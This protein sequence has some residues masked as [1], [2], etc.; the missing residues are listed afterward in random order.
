MEMARVLWLHWL[1]NH[2][3]GACNCTEDCS[4]TM[5]GFIFY[6]MQPNFQDN[7]AINKNCVTHIVLIELVL[8]LI[9]H[10]IAAVY[11]Q[12]RGCF[13]LIIDAVCK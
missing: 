13:K 7:I 8:T 1:P 6:A 2:F 11:L 9:I 5:H 3:R 12:M 10:S 4:A